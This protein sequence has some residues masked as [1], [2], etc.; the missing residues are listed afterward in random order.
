MRMAGINV[1]FGKWLI[2]SSP[3]VVLFDLNSARARLNEWKADLWSVAGI[4]SPEED[5]EMNDAIIFGY[6]TAWFLG[7]VRTLL[8]RIWESSNRVYYSLCIGI[9]SR[10]LLRTFTSGW[11]RLV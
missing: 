8:S 2:E 5:W 9:G 7:E 1:V 3:Y 11:H 4:P 6:L 10:L